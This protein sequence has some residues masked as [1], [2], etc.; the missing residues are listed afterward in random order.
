M[1]KMMDATDSIIAVTIM[2]YPLQERRT[3]RYFVNLKKVD[4]NEDLKSKNCKVFLC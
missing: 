3:P 1:S 2:R 4:K